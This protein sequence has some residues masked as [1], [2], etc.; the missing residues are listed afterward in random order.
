MNPRMINPV[1]SPLSML[2]IFWLLLLLPVLVHAQGPEPVSLKQVEALWRA[3]SRELALARISVGAAEADLQIAGQ[4]PNPELSLNLASISPST[5]YGSGPWKDKR[6]DNVLRVEQMLERG[7]K[8]ELR[9]RGAESRLEAAR[10]D[11]EDVS[12]VQL[13]V[14]RRAYYDLLLAQEK[15]RLSGEAADLYSKSVAIAEKRLKVGD[16]A[17]VELARLS[18]DRARAD[19]E[20]RQARHELEQ[21]RQ[22]LGYLI[23]RQA[24]AADLVAGDAWPASETEPGTP[25]LATR[26]DLAA[27]RQRMSA[28]E[29]ERDLARALRSRDINLGLQVER[30]NQGAPV[31]SFGLGVSIPLF[32]WHEHEGQI[33]RAEMELSAAQIGYD[34]QRAVVETQLGQARSALLA[35]RDR[36]QRLEQGLLADAGKVAAAAELAYGKGA[37]GLMDLL[38][39]RRTLRQVQI[40][41]ATARADYAK[42]RSDWQLMAEYGQEK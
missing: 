31:N 32:V 1:Q 15:L 35:A 8:R 12:R 29:A 26:P 40:E 10:F 21:A 23:G 28:A 42:A 2:R 16:I 14:L 17:P 6:M 19:N 30:N 4:R 33:Q 18:V 5:G 20:V 7:G 25:S 27:G 34:Q 39:A 11:E 24:E 9:V 22:A 37:M 38:D 41:A 13:G 3:H 36:L